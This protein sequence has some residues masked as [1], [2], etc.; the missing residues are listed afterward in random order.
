MV[1]LTVSPIFVDT[2]FVIALH[3]KG[4]VHHG[5]AR[6]LADRLS[7]TRQRFVTTVAILLEVGD[8]FA[9][10]G[11]W[12]VVAP[13]LKSVR[14]DEQFEV[15]G[16]DGELLQRATALRSEREDKDWGLTD[17]VSFVVMRDRNIQ[18]ALSADH[19]FV[20]AG[21]RALLSEV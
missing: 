17:C 16:V 6:A 12:S 5:S 1:R 20:Q 21:F 9:N 19:H 18:S 14:E 11:R 2:S 8:G 13:F 7:E 3:H 15:V 4:D 10:R